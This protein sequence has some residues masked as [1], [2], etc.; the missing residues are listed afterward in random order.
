MRSKKNSL[1]TLRGFTGFTPYGVRTDKSAFAFFYVGPTNISV[2]SQENVEAKVHRLMML[3]SAVPELEIL[4]LDSCE[5]FDSNKTYLKKR[6]EAE[7]NESVRN[8]LQA[9][10]LFLDEIQIGM[11]SA[12]QFLFAV[13][14]RKETDEQAFHMLNRIEKAMAEQGFS[15]RRL[16]KSDCKRMLALYFGTSITGDEIPDYEGENTVKPE[17]LNYAKE[18]NDTRTA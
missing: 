6:L 15:V 7:K 18:K 4:A 17:E 9:D 14:F 10:I 12:R 5:C 8:L 2:L 1:Q 16:T 11:S 3:M 13:R